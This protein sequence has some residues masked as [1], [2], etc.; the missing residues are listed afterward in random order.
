MTDAD[1]IFNHSI[2]S[3]LVIG[4]AVVCLLAGTVTPSRGME[5]LQTANVTAE[6]T[7][8]K[9][10]IDRRCHKGARIQ[11]P[12]EILGT[13]YRPPSVG[14]KVVYDNWGFT[15]EESR[16]DHFVMRSRANNYYTRYYTLLL[17]GK[18]VY[19]KTDRNAEE[20]VGVF[21]TPVLLTNNRSIDAVKSLWPLHVG[22]KAEYVAEEHAMSDFSKGTL[23]D[24]WVFRLEVEGI[25]LICAKARQLRTVVIN[26]D[27]ES[28]RGRKF[29]EKVWY[30][31]DSGLIV[32]A[33]RVWSGAAVPNPRRNTKPGDVQAYAIVELKE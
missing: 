32:K 8:G 22:N 18:E 3:W 2:P 1:Q 31:P 15:V 30:H 16:G 21:A 20:R 27:G 14:A 10:H 23:D 19:S 28:R 26:I 11:R 5:R 17:L 9:V 6:Q 4:A 12:H 33:R 29:N 24:R 25:G 13:H 7:T